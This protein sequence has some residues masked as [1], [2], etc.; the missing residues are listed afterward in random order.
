MKKYVRL[1]DFKEGS[2]EFIEEVMA[3]ALGKDARD[4]KVAE[5]YKH[6]SKG[7]V[8]ALKRF[9]NYL[10][11]LFSKNTVHNEYSNLYDF[12]NPL[13]TMGDL[14]DFITNDKDKLVLSDL[15]PV[16]EE[17]SL[18]Y[19]NLLEEG[20]VLED[21]ELQKLS[22][23]LFGVP[24]PRI[25]IEK[26]NLSKDYPIYHIL[27]T[28]ILPNYANIL[29]VEKER[30]KKELSKIKNQSMENPKFRKIWDKIQKNTIE[31]MYR[32]YRI[33]L[34]ML[35]SKRVSKK[36]LEYQKE[37]EGTLLGNDS[38]MLPD[39]EN[40]LLSIQSQIGFTSFETLKTNNNS[41]LQLLTE[42]I[43]RF[44]GYDK[45]ANLFNHQVYGKT[46]VI[47][48]GELKEIVNGRVQPL[49]KR[50]KEILNDFI[51]SKYKNKKS[52][53]KLLIKD[54]LK[55][56]SK[57]TG[58]DY[59]IHTAEGKISQ[60]GQLL[61]NIN[62]SHALNQNELAESPEDI[63][64]NLIDQ[65]IFFFTGATVDRAAMAHGEDFVGAQ[66]K[67]KGYSNF[68]KRVNAT[69]WYRIQKILNHIIGMEFQSD[70]FGKE[71]KMFNEEI[72]AYLA[73]PKKYFEDNY[74]KLDSGN[75]VVKESNLLNTM[76]SISMDVK[77]QLGYRYNVKQFLKL[78]SINKMDEF[79]IKLNNDFVKEI[80]KAVKDGII[81]KKVIPGKDLIGLVPLAGNIESNIL[82]S[83]HKKPL[84]AITN[85]TNKINYLFGMY[86]I[87]LI[88]KGISSE[89]A[90][91]KTMSLVA[92][93]IESTENSFL[94]LHKD[95]VEL[96][97]SHIENIKSYGQA[98]GYNH[99]TSLAQDK[100]LL[101]IYDDIVTGKAPKEMLNIVLNI[102]ETKTSPNI[103]LKDSA[104]YYLKDEYR[105]NR[106]VRLYLKDKHAKYKKISENYNKG[107]D[108]NSYAPNDS[109]PT[110][111]F[112]QTSVIFN[113]L[114]INS[115]G[116]L[117]IGKLAGDD[118][119][120][121][122]KKKVKSLIDNKEGYKI[123]WPYQG[124]NELKSKISKNEKQHLKNVNERNIIN[125]VIKSYENRD[126]NKF[127]KNALVTRYLSEMR[128][129]LPLFK[130]YYEFAIKRDDLAKKDD[131]NFDD[132]REYIE[133]TGKFKD[134]IK[135][136][137]NTLAAEKTLNPIRILH[138]I[139]NSF[140]P[141]WQDSKELEPIYIALGHAN[142]LSQSMGNPTHESYKFYHTKQESSWKSFKNNVND[143]N[144]FIRDFIDLTNVSE[145]YPNLIED[146]QVYLFQM[147]ET[148]QGDIDNWYGKN[149]GSFNG[150]QVSKIQ[151]AIIK[152]IS[153]ELK[154]K[155]SEFIKKYE[156]TK[157]WVKGANGPFMKD[158]VKILTELQD[159]GLIKVNV[160][161]PEF[162]NSQYI[163]I[164][165]LNIEKLLEYKTFRMQK[166][167]NEELN[168]KGKVQVKDMNT[169]KDKVKNRFSY[170][171]I[172]DP[173]L[174]RNIKINQIFKEAWYDLNLVEKQRLG[175]KTIVSPEKF[176]YAMI[177]SIPP[178]LKNRFLEWYAINFSKY[179][180]LKY[181]NDAEGKDIKTTLPQ[182]DTTN[183]M[184]LIMKL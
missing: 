51:N 53:D 184:K 16:Q 92:T 59:A 183:H 10:K 52:K 20:L 74:T 174:K 119:N 129:S 143:S 153:K 108:V 58:E 77:E 109:F 102:P 1:G 75:L 84:P 141:M 181:K 54:I 134:I 116:G 82:D 3:F 178:E 78:P 18:N 137:K 80:Q 29:M 69:G 35:G 87:G 57:M 118:K 89:K 99:N 56:Y 124:R 166:V 44:R 39:L 149:L 90:Y 70:L 81:D 22:K 66:Y 62:I 148:S 26:E 91:D 146:I 21:K 42:I 133:T 103:S 155:D 15:S 71:K 100:A 68:G 135:P 142:A 97:E 111:D 159:E 140:S 127:Y 45:I 83:F 34:S 177:A 180:D 128:T 5:K 7:F 163:K 171:K 161:V 120:I 32:Q 101:E 25:K 157:D 160:E 12:V 106:N 33:P 104:G 105:K 28:N 125:D 17:S 172:E 93:F 107:H 152:I 30:F 37:L 24:N 9:W 168:K 88:E 169:L 115:P 173:K 19:D 94:A 150:P 144:S 61:G 60:G 2:D 72:Q 43:F 85:K 27:N 122:L 170:Q 14:V 11:Q 65:R 49:P 46:G 98:G 131:L 96:E 8:Q 175:F 63:T 48:L 114:G 126:I 145:D 40:S 156:I 147:F 6:E 67:G 64:S 136:L 73:N 176:K 117:R 95:K 151:D 164:E 179:S 50:E 38:F 13:M 123:G 158:A 165:A 4:S 110:F 86:Y 182:T 23:E 55:D 79:K 139:Q 47:S 76:I 41:E 154:N 132:F 112:F 121:I 31:K 36:L 113:V 138:F 167:I 130:W 162:A